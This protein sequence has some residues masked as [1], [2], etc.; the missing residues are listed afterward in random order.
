M[1][2]DAC[3]YCNCVETGRLISPHPYPELLFIAE[4]GCPNIRSDDD[5]KVHAHDRWLDGSPCPH[6]NCTLCAHYIGSIGLVAQLRKI[7]SGLSANPETEYPILWLK[8]IYSG[9]HCGDFLNMDKV[10][11]LQTEVARLRSDQLRHLNDSAAEYLSSFLSQMGELIN[12]ALSVRKP[13]C[14]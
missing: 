6:E 1:G 10:S 12:A 14:F 7:I 8:V 11:I 3:V 9:S 2:L 5:E 4:N 13:I